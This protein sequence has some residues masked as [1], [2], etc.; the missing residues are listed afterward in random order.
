MSEKQLSFKT[1]AIWEQYYLEVLPFK[2]RRTDFR[3]PYPFSIKSKV[4]IKAPD[5]YRLIS[6]DENKKEAGGPFCQWRTQIA[7]SDN[8]CELALSCTLKAGV[9]D[10]SKY[11]AYQSLMEQVVGSISTEM[12]FMRN[13]A[14]DNSP[15]RADQIRDDLDTP[16]GT[17]LKVK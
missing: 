8:T 4:A 2:D 10:S 14:S 11:P 15:A 5:S 13:S 6:V 16:Q 3:I 12:H 1:P 7:P 9:F 17:N